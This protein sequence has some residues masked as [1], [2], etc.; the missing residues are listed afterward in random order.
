MR[1]KSFLRK[2]LIEAKARIAAELAE[3]LKDNSKDPEIMAKYKEELA[4][5]HEEFDKKLKTRISELEKNILNLS[6]KE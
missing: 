3:F 2:K 5:L 1:F 4:I 6:L